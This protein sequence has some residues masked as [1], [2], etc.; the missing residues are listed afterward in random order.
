MAKYYLKN[1][2]YVYLPIILVFMKNRLKSIPFKLPLLAWKNKSLVT[3]VAF[4]IFLCFFDKYNLRTQYKIYS[5]L[6]NMQDQKANYIHLIAEAK[7]DKFDLEQNYER[8]AREKYFMSRL[9][10]DVFIIE[11]KKIIKK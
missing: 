1:K 6:L 4:L 3:I 5:T 11:T 9:D 2:L 8:F 10:E 7:Q